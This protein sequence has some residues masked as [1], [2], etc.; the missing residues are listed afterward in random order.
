M[1]ATRAPRC[2]S[3]R[4]GSHGFTLVELMVTVAILAI[5]ATIGYPSFQELLASQRVR[6]AEAALYDSLLIAR[7]EA[8]KNRASTTF[9]TTGLASG[10][11]VQVGG[12]VVHSQSAL[13]G[14]S[15]TPSTPNIAYDATGRLGVGT[16]PL[17]I[18]VTV[19]GSGSTSKLCI[20]IRDQTGS[21]KRKKDGACP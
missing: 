8:L 13:A 21:V 5:L 14:V 18:T 2:P 12:Q 7:S 1:K 20:E 3:G 11:S 16:D 10:W 6:A 9:V 17:P 19:T 15:F 4:H